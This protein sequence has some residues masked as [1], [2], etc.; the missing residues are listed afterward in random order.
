MH[1]NQEYN[2]CVFSKNIALLNKQ[3]EEIRSNELIQCWPILL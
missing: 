1:L 3:I 2:S